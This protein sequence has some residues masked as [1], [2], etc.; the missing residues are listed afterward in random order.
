MPPF[1]LLVITDVHYTSDAATAAGA[2][3]GRHGRIGRELLRRAVEDARRRGGFDAIALLGDLVE[4]GLAPHAPGDLQA[5]AAELAT[6]APDT[7]LLVV[8]GNHD[9]PAQ[10]VLDAFACRSGLVELGGYRFWAF[11]DAYEQ[12]THGTRGEADRRRLGELAARP[13]GPI[14]AIQHNPIHPPIVSDYPYMLTNGE[15]IRRDYEEAGVLLSIS[16]HYHAGQELTVADG[17]RYYTAPALSERP[18]GYALVTF[19]GREVAVEARRLS[20]EPLAIVDTHAH[21]EFAYCGRG[22][23]AAGAIERARTFGLA[24]VCLTEHAPQLYCSAE[25]FWAASHVRSP[26]VWRRG[27]H[28]RMAEFRRCTEP[29]RSDFV[30]V[31]LEVE[32]DADGHLT[33]HESDRAWIDRVVGAVHWMPEDIDHLSDA[34]ATTAFLNVNEALLAGGVDVLAHPWR[35]LRAAG[36]CVP[37]QALAPM[38]EMLAATDTA[39]E[40]NFHIN[41][42]DVTFFRECLDRGVKIALGSDAHQPWEAGLLAANVALLVEAAGSEDVGQ[43][44]LV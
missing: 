13:G 10:A 34:A 32:L 14:V 16:G 40:I 11:C 31:G 21:T 36:R 2:A 12:A 15:A 17:V 30:R 44:L 42:P 26:E 35:F 19:R 38:A 3:A 25:E 1:R 5:L 28:S 33:L 8:A 20:V 37:A 29:L 23:T 9:G 39:A 18:F 27:A 43:Y 6:A 22:V 7:P 41:R 24:G 4:D